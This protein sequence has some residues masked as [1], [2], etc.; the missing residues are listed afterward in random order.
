M[1]NGGGISLSYSSSAIINNIIT[2]NSGDHGGGI[3]CG[4]S[5]PTIA[6]NT[7]TWNDAGSTGSGISC[8]RDSYL[9]IINT[10]VWNA[11]DEV[12]VAPSSD[13]NITYSDVK[14]GWP[15]EGNI[16][17]DPLFVDP[18]N[19]DY[20][21]QPGSPC[22]DA[23][24]PLGAPDDDIEGN[25]RDEFPDMGAYEYQKVGTGSIDGTVTDLEGNLI[26]WALVI[27]VDSETKEKYND[28][29]DINSYYGIL[30]IPV[31][32]YWVICIKKGYK[33]GLKKA[34][35]LAGETTTVDFM[36][37]PKLE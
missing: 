5:S 19:G 36:L 34:E 30:D 35:V 13:I 10:I 7:I 14:G 29:T 18:D 2:R 23:G 16:D 20:H 15:G 4:S 33:A 11:N 27:A 21:L 26:K 31:G 22:I 17:A 3:F 32:T 8:W 9:K 25:P 12:Y 1:G 28:F 6:N 37:T 24:T